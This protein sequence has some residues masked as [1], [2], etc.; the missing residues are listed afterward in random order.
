MTFIDNWSRYGWIYLLKHK[1]DAFKAFKTFKAM[2]EKQYNRPI[3]CFHKDKGGEYIGHVWDEFFAEHGIQ[4]EHTQPADAAAPALPNIKEESD[5]AL[6][7]SQ[8]PAESDSNVNPFYM[9]PASLD[10]FDFLSG[11]TLARHA[12]ALSAGHQVC[13][14][15]GRRASLAPASS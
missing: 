2:V 15:R 13:L 1:S 6:G 8:T 10:E 4:R 7:P 5:H 12:S 9:A 14:Q 3:L 11:S